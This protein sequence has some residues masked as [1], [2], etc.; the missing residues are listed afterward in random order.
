MGIGNTLARIA[1]IGSLLL[2]ANC[3]QTKPWGKVAAY[4]DTRGMP[5]ASVTGGAVELPLGSQAYGFMDIKTG[6]EDLDNIQDPYMEISLAKKVSLDGFGEGI[7]KMFEKSIGPIVE[8]NR[9]FAEPKGVTRAGLVFEPDVSQFTKDAL[10][11]IN[12]YPIATADAGPQVVFYG[13]KTF[14]D[15]NWYVEGF[16]DYNFTH[17]RVVSEIQAGKR[18]WGNLNAVVE[19]RHNGF[20]EDE[21]GVGFGLEFL[22]K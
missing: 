13:T 19:G 5:T 11:G 10:V 18:I 3:A 20:L 15:G 21:W 7:G 22:L 4:Y 2:G 8:Y 16:F 14:G 1:F 9:D 6:R 12:F 17:S